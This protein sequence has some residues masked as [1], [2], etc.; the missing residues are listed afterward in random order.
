MRVFSFILVAVNILFLLLGALLY[1]YAERTGT[2]VPARSDDLFPTFAMGVFPPWLGLLF[3]IGL[4]SALFPSADGALTALTAST[5]IDLI[6][7]RDRG[8]DE[9]RQRTVRRRVHLAMAGVF[10]LCILFFE[11]LASGT[12]LRTLL[13]IAGYTYGPLLGLFGFGIF[14]RRV[15]RDN[16]VPLV[17]LVAPVLTYLLKTYSPTLFF[18]YQMGFEILIVNGAITF[19]GL[20]LI[21]RGG[22]TAGR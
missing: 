18:G 14:T 7:I 2:P 19:L 15:P 1:L 16:R 22:A 20:S 10:F 4:V 12:V 9:S 8:W 21:S 3:V 17:C 13:E 11:W 6:G 5:C